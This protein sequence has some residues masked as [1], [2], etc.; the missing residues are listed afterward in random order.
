VTFEL[1]ERADVNLNVYNINGKL[2]KT[3]NQQSMVMGKHTVDLDM[4]GIGKGTYIIQLNAGA[5][6]DV[7]RFIK[8][9]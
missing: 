9:K 2:I 7:T 3:I 4:S 8:L 5:I 6:S 1:N